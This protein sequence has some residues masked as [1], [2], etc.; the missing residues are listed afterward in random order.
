MTWD[1]WSDEQL[2]RVRR[3]VMSNQEAEAFIVAIQK[4]RRTLREALHSALGYLS[5]EDN[6][7]ARKIC[8]DAALALTDFVGFA[9]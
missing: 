6:P 3:Q 8:Q 4:E 9:G 7:Q 2:D 5:A 1:A